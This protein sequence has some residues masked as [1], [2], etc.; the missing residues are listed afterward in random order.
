[1]ISNLIDLLFNWPVFWFSC[2]GRCYL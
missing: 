2:N 1:M